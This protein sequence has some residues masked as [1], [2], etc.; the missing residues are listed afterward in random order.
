MSARRPGRGAWGGALGLALCLGWSGIVAAALH[1]P[2]LAVRS[3]A[4]IEDVRHRHGLLWEIRAPGGPRSY[5]FG[6]I[7]LSSPEVTA[8][9]PA[10]TA[11]LLGARRFGMEVLLDFETLMRVADLMRAKDDERLASHADPD[12]LARTREL[13]ATYGV[14]AAAADDLKPWAAYTTL[15]LPPGQSAVPLDLL[16]LGTAEKRG[17][18]LF[19]LE[20]LEEQAA[21]FERMSIADQMALLKDAVCH[22]ATL[23]AETGQMIAHYRE[24]DL[25]ALYRTAQR[26]NSGAQQRLM[27]VLLTQR[28]RRMF[29]RL[30]PYLEAGDAFI[31]VGALHLPGPG[32]LLELLES[33][34]YT[35]HAME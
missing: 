26:Y 17:K 35:L 22:Y 9:R 7:H 1:C 33:N 20:S 25:N 34:G 28:N 3:A 12:L 5:L 18:E 19:G 21:V 15:S 13:L 8:L 27:D 23:Q 6:T 16:L 29:D 32:G 30:Q 11:A 24:Q 14:S 31:A 10:V 2:P 4:E